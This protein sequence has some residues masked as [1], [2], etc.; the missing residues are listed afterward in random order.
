[1]EIAVNQEQL[2]ILLN[3]VADDAGELAELLK[4]GVM[5]PIEDSLSLAMRAAHA[6]M[7]CAELAKR[8]MQYHRETNR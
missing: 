7:Q 8:L 2:T 1:M 6:S 5:P 4:Q 3:D